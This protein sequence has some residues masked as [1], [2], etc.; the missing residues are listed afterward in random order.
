MKTLKTKQE[1][2]SNLNKQLYYSDNLIKT[3]RIIK[4]M[5]LIRAE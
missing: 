4:L 2:L 1:R 5:Q 3:N